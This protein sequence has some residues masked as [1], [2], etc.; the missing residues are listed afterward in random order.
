M[1]ALGTMHIDAP[2]EDDEDEEESES[3]EFL[4]PYVFSGGIEWDDQKV[5]EASGNEGA[6][7]ERWYVHTRH[8]QVAKQITP[9]TK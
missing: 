4:P 6:T 8:T 9:H 2:D 1:I 7:M 5:E 3:H